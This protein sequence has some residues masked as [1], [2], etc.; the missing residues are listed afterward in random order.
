M[1]LINLS[2]ILNSLG[3]IWTMQCN[4]LK[5]FE[6][7]ADIVCSCRSLLLS[8][9]LPHP[10]PWHYG[11]WMQDPDKWIYLY[12]PSFKIH[13]FVVSSET[14]GYGANCRGWILYSNIMFTIQWCWKII[15]WNFSIVLNFQMFKLTSFLP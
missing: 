6:H 14:F 12:N 1:G 11:K 15:I 8:S 13:T 3:C 7:E 10:A 5:W 4:E 2:Q 9:T